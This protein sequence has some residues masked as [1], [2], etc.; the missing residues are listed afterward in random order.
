MMI[1]YRIFTMV[2]LVYCSG[3]VV[4]IQG[5]LTQELDLPGSSIVPFTPIFVLI[6]FLLT[7]FLEKISKW[8]KLIWFLIGLLMVYPVTIYRTFSHSI[9]SPA[10][11]SSADFSRFKNEFRVLAIYEPSHI[12]VAKQDFR[13]EMETRVR[14]MA[15][16]AKTKAEAKAP[17]NLLTNPIK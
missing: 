9:E 8:F 12:T 7:V 13:P 1:F 17:A 4:S 3:K 5:P 14:E 6:A 15:E 16:A 2:I 11:L 10:S